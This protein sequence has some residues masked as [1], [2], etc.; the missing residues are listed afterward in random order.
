MG[1][2]PL[3]SD[4]DDQVRDFYDPGGS[5]EQPGANQDPNGFF[6]ENLRDTMTL[7]TNMSGTILY[8]LFEEFAMDDGDTLWIFDGPNVNAPL[9]GVYNLVQSPGEVSA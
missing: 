7:R 8:V 2:T 9:Y 3:V 4:I 5:P 1:T 6:A